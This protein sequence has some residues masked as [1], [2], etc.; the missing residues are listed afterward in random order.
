VRA[1]EL[2]TVELRESDLI[3][4]DDEGKA[5][6]VLWARSV[7]YFEDEQK[8]QAEDV[9]VRFLDGGRE[10]L[11]VRAERLIFDHR[12]GDLTISGGVSAS[13]PEGLRLSV[14]EA[15]WDDEERVLSSDSTVLVE[16][17]DLRLQGQG[18]EY[19]PDEG[20]L[21]IKGAKLKLFLR[22]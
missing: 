22:E 12:S 6:W 10:V 18:F 11:S 3:R 20:T 2:P 17:G 19:R 1:P 21:T 4:Y 13:D 8:T 16:R 15:Y 7:Q 9:E 5:V 14:E